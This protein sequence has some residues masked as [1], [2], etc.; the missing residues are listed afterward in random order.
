M[1]ALLQLVPLYDPRV[2]GGQRLK[3]SPE[4][5]IGEAWVVYERNPVASG[6]LAGHTLA[7]VAAERGAALVGRHAF[8]RTGTR[9]PLLIKLLDCA[10]WLSIQVHPNDAQ[11]IQMEGPGEFGKTEAWHVLEAEEGARLIAGVQPGT[12]A[13][14][15][16]T[17]IRNG[18]IEPYSLYHTVHAGDTIFMPA[19]LMHALGP[20]LLLYEVQQTSDLTYRVF[21]WDRPASAGRPLHI[22]QS[23]AVTNPGLAGKTMPLPPLGAHDQRSLVRCKYFDLSLLVAQSKQLQLDT[24]D[25]SFHALTVIEGKV[26][27]IWGEE[28]V[29]LDRFETVVVSADAGAYRLN[30]ITPC[31]VLSARVPPEG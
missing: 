24:L 26:E 19:G 25:E 21:D 11:A 14:E 1:S 3:N 4:N 5:P 27:V 30:P 22:E 18:T 10:D 15:L 6:P 7:E 29:I 31:R 13:A 8:A 12:S 17:A 16:A 20:G 2:W 9:F 28:Q 23:V